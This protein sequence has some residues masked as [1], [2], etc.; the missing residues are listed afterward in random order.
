MQGMLG[1]RSE[2]YGKHN[3]H[4]ERVVMKL[5]QLYTCLGLLNRGY[6]QLVAVWQL[7]PSGDG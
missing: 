3:S 4:H 6:I 7:K 2:L 1:T 5:V